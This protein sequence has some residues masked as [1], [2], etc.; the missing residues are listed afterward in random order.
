MDKFISSI[1]AVKVPENLD[2]T[3]D[4]LNAIKSKAAEPFDI[5]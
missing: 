2:L 1:Q 3:T 4:E 5:I